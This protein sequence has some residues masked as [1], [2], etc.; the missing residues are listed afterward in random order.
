MIEGFSLR[1]CAE[2]LGDNVT[3]VTLFYWRHKLLSA[4]KQIPTESFNG[5]VEMDETYFLYFGKR[6]KQYNGSQTTITAD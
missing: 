5:I 4:I 2:L 3:H 6:K 1:K